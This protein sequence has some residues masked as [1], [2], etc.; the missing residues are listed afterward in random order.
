M[1]KNFYQLL[2]VNQNANQEEIVANYNELRE[3][4]IQELAES[5]DYF[6]ASQNIDRLKQCCNALLTLTDNELRKDYDKFI[7]Q[8]DSEYLPCEF[9]PKC[10]AVFWG[11]VKRNLDHCFGQGTE[12]KSKKREIYLK[13][14]ESLW[15][16]SVDNNYNWHCFSCYKPYE[17]LVILSENEG[18]EK[19]FCLTCYVCSLG[20]SVGREHAA[21]QGPI[22]D[23]DF[24]QQIKKINLLEIEYGITEYFSV[25]FEGRVYEMMK[26][27]WKEFIDQKEKFWF[28]FTRK[29]NQ[30]WDKETTDNWLVFKENLPAMA[31]AGLITSWWKNHHNWFCLHCLKPVERLIVNYDTEKKSRICLTCLVFLQSVSWG[32]VGH[33]WGEERVIHDIQLIKKVEEDW[34]ISEPG[35]LI[36][37]DQISKDFEEYWIREGKEKHSKLFEKNIRKE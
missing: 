4:L 2:G 13:K 31:K 17:K 18:P 37:Y 30:Y 11:V 23:E 15:G 22:V 16:F 14:K 24:Y 7:T 36:F 6:Q 28:F 8:F 29:V 26:S 32:K 10:W 20:Q 27:Y 35:E 33:K 19:G 34:E 21:E 3:K 1:N 25:I 5:E 12:L 9:S